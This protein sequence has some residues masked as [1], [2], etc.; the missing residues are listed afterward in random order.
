M[1]LKSLLRNA[2]N[3]LPAGAAES[4]A[5]T[6]RRA[7]YPFLRRRWRHAAQ[8]MR[9]AGNPQQVLRGP[10]AGMAYI[11]RA[12]Y[13]MVEAKLL[14]TYELE[15]HP[16]INQ[17]IAE[18]PRTIIDIGAAEGYYAVGLAFR[19]PASHVVAFE[20][21]ARGRQLL[22]QLAA[23]NG[24]QDRIRVLG[25]A[26]VP[27]LRDALGKAAGGVFVIC[28]VEGY[29]DVLLDPQAVPDLARAAMLVE[30]HDH[31]NPGVGD[32]IEARFNRTHE[33][34]I[35]HSR[36]RTLAD[37]PPGLAT[38]DVEAADAVWERDQ[39]MR[40]FHLSPRSTG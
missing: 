36:P 24:V 31:L 12:F 18:A 30:I 13:G 16:V 40:W 28:D 39:L 2:V 8:V 10:F 33:V 38:G 11:P 23:L 6:Y 1:P 4:I 32:R 22:A 20:M 3:L 7:R 35:L 34:R 14:G 26:D 9:A 17:V 25:A 21:E 15:L 27:A 19:M 5:R 29:E 37:L